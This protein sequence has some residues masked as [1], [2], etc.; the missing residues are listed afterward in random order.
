MPKV[1]KIS[2]KAEE[3]L[4]EE[5]IVHANIGGVYHF[6]LY[7]GYGDSPTELLSEFSL[8]KH[9]F[10][11]VGR[12]LLLQSEKK[13]LPSMQ[14]VEKSMTDFKRGRVVRNTLSGES[15]VVTGNYGD[16]ALAVRTVDISNPAEWEI[17][18]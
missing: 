10:V 6:D 12:V 18:E 13:D 5:H 16:H 3:A 15:Y 7:Q 14:P 1:T 17:V 2:L 11:V 8:G 4:A 9:Q